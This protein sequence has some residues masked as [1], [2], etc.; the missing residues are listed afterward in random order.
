MP[1]SVKIKARGK[2]AA[3]KDPAPRWIVTEDV[4]TVG[5]S[6]SYAAEG[7]WWLLLATV[8]LKVFKKPTKQLKVKLSKLIGK[9][10]GSCE[11]MLLGHRRQLAC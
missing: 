5:T 11:S 7:I 4:T 6:S 2:Q 8:F 3:E 1:H 10:E 9:V